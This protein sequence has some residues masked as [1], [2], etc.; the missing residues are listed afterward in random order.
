[1]LEVICAGSLFL[2]LNHCSQN[3]APDLALIN[4]SQSTLVQS[5]IQSDVLQPEKFPGLYLAESEAEADYRRNL[6]Q[7]MDQFNIII[8]DPNSDQDSSDRDAE[9]RRRELEQ[10]DNNYDGVE[11]SGNDHESDYSQEAEDARNGDGYDVDV[12]DSDE[13]EDSSDRDAAERR[14]ELEAEHQSGDGDET[15]DSGDEHTSEYSQQA[16]DARNGDFS[17]SDENSDEDEDSSDRDAAERRQE[18]G[19]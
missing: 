4:A 19:F 18:L 8:Q 15:E 1:M 12:S 10:E 6:E 5:F 11:D 13:D 17:S 16:E 3:E 2:S 9:Q 7:L 14:R